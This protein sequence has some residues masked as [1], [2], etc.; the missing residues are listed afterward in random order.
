MYTAICAI[1]LFMMILLILTLQSIGGHKITFVSESYIQ[2]VV[3]SSTYFN[4]M[5]TADLKARCV[6]SKTAYKDKYITSF[7]KFSL[8]EKYHLWHLVSQADILIKHRFPSLYNIPWKFAKLN[9][10]LEAGFPHTLGDIIILSDR[11][12]A[13]PFQ[14]FQI[15]TIIHE[16]VHVLQRLKPQWAT[17]V[18]HEW[19][20]VEYNIH[21]DVP[22]RR[23][24]PDLPQSVFGLEDG[25]IM[26]LYNSDEPKSL[27]DSSPAVIKKDEIVTVNAM[28]LQLP[29]YVNQVEHPYEIMACMVPEL[30]LG[31]QS[32]STEF[33]YTLLRH[34]SN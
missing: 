24:N 25:P 29:L 28:D 19:G 34:M 6:P 3:K 17:K 10:S 12:F 14:T 21:E 31:T 11:F 5:N 8:K 23:N 2:E 22:P 16:K 27:S 1:S 18:I 32:P 4:N 9:D 20:F 26:Q 13:T 30:I 33:E 7:T 15:N